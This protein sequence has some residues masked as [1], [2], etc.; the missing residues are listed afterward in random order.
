MKWQ[1]NEIW[2]DGTDRRR[3]ALVI[4]DRPS[5]DGRFSAALCGLH[6]GRGKAWKASSCLWVTWRAWCSSGPGSIFASGQMDINEN[7]MA[8]TMA[9]RIPFILLLTGRST[10][11][12]VF[13][14]LFEYNLK[15]IFEPYLQFSGWWS[16]KSSFQRLPWRIFCTL[17]GPFTEKN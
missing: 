5:R 9:K 4:C 15:Q 3:G 12:S 6:P 2:M 10:T 1:K 14:H 16:H 13:T 7:C 11:R 17:C 8:T